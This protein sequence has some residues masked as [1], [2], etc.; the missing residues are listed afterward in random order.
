MKKNRTIVKFVFIAALM[1]FVSP[2]V[3]IESE[4]SSVSLSTAAPISLGISLFHQA[5]ARP[6]RRQ[7]RRV[8]RRTSRRTAHRVNHRHNAARYYGGGH[9]HYGYYGG[10]AVVGFAAGLAVG[11]IVSAATMPTTCVTTYVNGVSYRRCGSAY[12]QPVYQGDTVVYR[13]VNP[14]L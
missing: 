10:R 1:G 6:V 7:S 8:A 14:P 3:N 4:N 9:R 2:S 12:Y 11:S 5:E 13:V